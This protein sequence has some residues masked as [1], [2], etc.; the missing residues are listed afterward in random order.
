M[1]KLEVT[2]IMIRESNE[3]DSFENVNYGS[4]V[5]YPAGEKHLYRDFLV[6]G[7]NDDSLTTVPILPENKIRPNL[8]TVIMTNKINEFLGGTYYAEPLNV[9]VIPKSVYEQVNAVLVA[10]LNTDELAQID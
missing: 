3:G 4:I 9:A 8:F 5:S 1:N 10:N 2:R 7:K 6:L